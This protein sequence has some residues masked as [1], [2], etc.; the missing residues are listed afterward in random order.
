MYHVNKTGEPCTRNIRRL[1]ILNVQ[2]KI[3][4]VRGISNAQPINSLNRCVIPYYSHSQDQSVPHENDEVHQQDVQ[5]C[6]SGRVE[7][8]KD[9]HELREIAGD[10]VLI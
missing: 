8:Q 6:Y 5:H 4:A 2:N 9:R 1:C 7:S 3:K 10:K